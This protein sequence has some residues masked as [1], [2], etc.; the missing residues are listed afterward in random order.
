MRQIGACKEKSSQALIFLRKI[1]KK[2]EIRRR[3]G[4]SQAKFAEKYEIP[5]R[6]LENWEQGSRKCPEYVYNLLDRVVA[7]DFG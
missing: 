6:T 2:L 5:K 3:S 7:E 4:L 1:F